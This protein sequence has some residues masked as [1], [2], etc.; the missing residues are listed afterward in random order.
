MIILTCLINEP[1][2]DNEY[3]ESPYNAQAEYICFLKKC[4]SKNVYY[5]LR[6]FKSIMITILANELYVIF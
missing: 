5:Q 2:L 3:H 6:I 4:N 1:L